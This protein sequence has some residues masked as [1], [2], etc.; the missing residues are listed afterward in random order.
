M[1]HGKSRVQVGTVADMDKKNVADV[2][3]S[4]V[5]GLPQKF[6]TSI[7]IKPLADF[8]RH[9]VAPGNRPSVGFILMNENIA[10]NNNKMLITANDTAEK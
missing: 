4:V 6:K 10:D 8:N 9:C 5:N 2:I 3:D 1:I 7:G